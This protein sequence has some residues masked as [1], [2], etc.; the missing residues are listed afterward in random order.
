MGQS[1][2]GLA[3]VF[4]GIAR[5]LQAETNP[6]KTQERVTRAA[7]ATV[8]GCDHASIS[9]VRR[10]DTIETVASTDDVPNRVDAI[11]YDAFLS[12][13]IVPDGTAPTALPPAITRWSYVLA[14]RIR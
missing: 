7:V 14:L 5:Q 1:E 6:E 8:D 2:D 13:P 12:A 4:A 10:H 11:Q 3:E 9:I